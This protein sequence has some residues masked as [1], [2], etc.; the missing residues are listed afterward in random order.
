MRQRDENDLFHFPNP[1]V[2]A[3]A[4]A[5]ACG[6]LDIDCTL[7][8]TDPYDLET[9]CST[10]ENQPQASMGMI[11]ECHLDGEVELMGPRGSDFTTFEGTAVVHRE[12]SC[13]TESCWFGIEGLELDADG[14]SSEGYAGLAIHASLAYE[15]FGLFAAGTHD[16]TIAPR[17]FGLDVTLRGKT[18][19]TS[20]QRYAF[21]MGNSDPAVFVTSQDQLQI[22]DASFAWDDHALVLTTALADCSCTN[23]S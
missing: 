9:T 2:D 20:S 7:D 4:G 21:R 8:E 1:D 13:T 14:F 16:A 15:G 18:P 11:L 5:I 22:V 10:S 6:T 19:A 12:R 3:G 23:C 17:M